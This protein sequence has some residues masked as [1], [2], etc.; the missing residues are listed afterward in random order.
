MNKKPLTPG[1]QVALSNVRTA[2]ISHE[3]AK[4][5]RRAEIDRRMADVEARIAI[6]VDARITALDV[7]LDEALLAA[8]DAGVS[9]RRIAHEAM[10]ASHDG[11]VRRMIHEALEDRRNEELDEHAGKVVSGN[12]QAQEIAA[13]DLERSR[14]EHPIGA[15]RFTLDKAEYVLY[16]DSTDRITA[17]TAR[18]ELD[19]F[20]PWI[21]SVRENGRKGSEFLSATECTIYRNPGDGKIVALESK[22]VGSTFYDHLA[23]RWVKDHQAEAAAGYDAVLASANLASA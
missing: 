14:E 17:P 12:P 23:A 13:L 7:E 9:I 3:V 1:Q 22:E 15:P 5:T 21:A 10:N 18:L 6:E 16:E 4:R 8:V 2:R 11:S 20:D 19:P